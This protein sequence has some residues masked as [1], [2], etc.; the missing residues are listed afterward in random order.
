MGKLILVRH[1]KTVL[2]SL[3][4]EERLRGW[5]DISLDEQGLREAEETA[6]RLA[7]YPVAHIYSSDL[8]RAKQTA[9]AVVRATCAPI[10]HTSDLRPWN[11]GTLAGQR[12][13]DILPTL[14]QLELD[15]ALSAP[16]GES[17]H[18]FCD[19]YSRKLEELLDIA[20]RSAACIVAVT[21][22]RNLLAAPALLHGGD[23]SHIPVRG[24]PKTG[25]L[26]WVEKNG[27]GWNLR[28]DEAPELGQVG[29]NSPVPFRYPIQTPRK[30]PA[31]A[32]VQA[33]TFPQGRTCSMKSTHPQPH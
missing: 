28:V 19:R 26:V 15:P 9:E 21:H 30:D 31:L 8:Y 29:R 18:Q 20:A 33:N 27:K 14:Q 11:L 6:E 17:F 12:V 16:G 2:N 7:Q 1:G 24:G 32:R 5:L 22:V 25:S 4:S 23:R 3:D 13:N 10:V